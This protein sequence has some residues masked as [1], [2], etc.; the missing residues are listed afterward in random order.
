M[1]QENSER[2]SL[3]LPAALNEELFAAEEARTGR[4]ILIMVGGGLRFAIFADEA[5]SVSVFRTPTPLPQA[6]AAVL[7]VTGVKGRMITVLDPVDLLGQ[8]T[9]TER[10][11]LV[12]L[13]GDEQLGLAIE[14]AEK[15]IDVQP[16]DIDSS[17]QS[18]LVYGIVM[19]D[20]LP[21]TIIDTSKLFD[22]AVRGVDRRRPRIQ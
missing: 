1:A 3:S 16:E 18:G 13:K 7:G 22:E 14:R 6:P 20:G 8:R 15:I 4:Q 17:N 21:V 19:I 11:F 9:S 12:E 2:P 10:N 5:E